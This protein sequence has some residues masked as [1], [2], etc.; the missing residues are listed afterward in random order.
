[1]KNLITSA[2]IV[3][4]TLA[5][6]ATSLGQMPMPAGGPQ[7]VEIGFTAVNGTQ[8]TVNCST[9]I[10]G[11]GRSGATAQLQDLRF[12]VSNVRMVRANG[13]SVKLTPMAGDEWN[14]TRAGQSVTLIDLED[15]T[16]A[17]AADGDK[18]MNDMV[19]G[20]VPAGKYVGVTMT[21]G[22]P[23]ALNHT[24]PTTTPA[25]LNLIGMGWSW[26]AGRKYT[27][28]ELTKPTAPGGAPGK[29]FMFHLGSTGC[30]GNPAAGDSITCRA[31]NRMKVLFKRFNPATQRIAFDIR[32][33]TA[34]L[35]LTVD[36]G[37]APG[38]MSGPKDPE[39]AVMRRGAI[40]WRA[41]GSGTGRILGDGTLQRLFRVVKG[42]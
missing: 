34:G 6:P 29:D 1:M 4:A 19:H 40:D 38:C 25:P 12:Y 10:T 27:K 9:P 26:Q 30:V 28:I 14:L 5:V 33:L 39:C 11:L 21:V 41:D 42:A 31:P 18:R 20:T 13:T 23:L 16:G 8:R 32:T 17:C 24:D 36:Q 7:H 3:A 37:G 35:D 22:V 2:A 15:G